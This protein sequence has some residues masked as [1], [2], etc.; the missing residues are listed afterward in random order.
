VTLCGHRG[1]GPAGD[2]YDWRETLSL[3]LGYE[4][5]KQPQDFGI[6]AHF[7]GRSAVN[8]GVPLL[9]ESGIGLQVGTAINATANAVQVME[10]VEG[11]TS[12]TQSFSTLGCFQRTPGGWKWAAAYDFLYQ[13]YYD[14]F[15][16]SQCRGLVGYQL[17]DANEVGVK[18]AVHTDDDQGDFGGVPVTLRAINQGSVY[19][20]HTYPNLVQLSCWF[21]VAEGHSEANIALGDLPA[22]DEA[23]VYG[24]DVFVPLNDYCAI[25]GEANF[26]TP[27]D[28][29]T[30][31]AY[32]GM[33]LFCWGGAK[34]SR[35]QRFT[36]VL[37]VAGNTSFSVDLLR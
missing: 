14:D 13:D 31:D 32:L 21:G 23:F 36:P 4:G 27:A 10:R 25:F 20:K 3:F 16:L 12:R 15:S 11:T 30:V 9:E 33:E 17:S 26:M 22:Q 2:R 6:N 7:G 18:S 35:Q 1:W 29:G 24:T 37:P 8:W 34:E 19:Y 5:S 28:T